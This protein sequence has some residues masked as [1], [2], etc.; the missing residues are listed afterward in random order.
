[1]WVIFHKLS[2]MLQE[3][4]T[5]E[6]WSSTRFAF[7]FSVLISNIVIFVSVAILIFQNGTIPDIPEGVL[8]LYALANG[9]AFTG[10]V[11]QKFKEQ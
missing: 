9:I 11:V 1:M 4:A 2:A 7:I 6:I 10:K 5:S 3:N 8:F